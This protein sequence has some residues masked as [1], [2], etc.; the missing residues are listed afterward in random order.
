ES[1]LTE[2]E[3]LAR[4]RDEA[5]RAQQE[6][7]EA[8]ASRDRLIPQ[9]REA[10]EKLVLATLRA[11]EL[12]AEATAARRGIEA[13]EERFRTLVTTSAAIV[14]SACPGGRIHMNP[15]SWRA[16]TGLEVPGGD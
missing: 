14:F 16:F 13:S 10:N 8:A 5:Q 4:L 11:D 7:R 9:M 15:E 12:A 3:E 1:S 6:A 2:R